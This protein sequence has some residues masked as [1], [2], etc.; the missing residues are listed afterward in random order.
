MQNGSPPLNQILSDLGDGFYINQSNTD[1]NFNVGTNLTVAA[2]IDLNII[3]GVVDG[4]VN[5]GLSGGVNANAQINLN[6]GLAVNNKIRFSELSAQP[7]SNIFASS[8]SITVSL[9]LVLDWYYDLVFIHKHGTDTVYTFGTWTL[10]SWNTAGNVTAS[11]IILGVTSNLGST[12]GG[13]SV[14]I[15]GSNL[16]SATVTFG[17]SPASVINDQ[18]SYILVTTPSGAAG[19]ANV[20]VTTAGGTATDTNGYTYV[21]PPTVTALSTGSVTPPGGPESGGNQV[22]ITGTNLANATAVNFGNGGLGTIISDTASTIVAWAAGGTGLVDITFTLG[23]T[24]IV[25]AADK[26][27]YVPPPIITSIVPDS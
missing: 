4:G 18:P 24:S 14:Y 12:L 7:L 23:G 9:S 3:P 17:G 2:G 1:L 27:M 16:S 21:A 22:T 13:T 15:Y 10:W 5:V 26:Y 6:P 25:S 8:G 11:P 20:K 19:P